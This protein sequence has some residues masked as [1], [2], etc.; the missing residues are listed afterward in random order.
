MEKIAEVKKKAPEVSIPLY[1][2]IRY[3]TFTD[4]RLC[5]LLNEMVGLHTSMLT[6]N[7]N[8]L[9]LLFVSCSTVFDRAIDEHQ[10]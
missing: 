2:D 8:T 1:Y 4:T 7:N 5:Q 6:V 3:Q 10:L 9:N